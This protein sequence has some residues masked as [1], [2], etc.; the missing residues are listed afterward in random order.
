MK[1][2]TLILGMMGALAA[3]LLVGAPSAVADPATETDYAVD[4]SIPDGLPNV[5]DCYDG[6]VEGYVAVR[7]CLEK[8]GDELWVRD[9]AADGHSVELF[10]KNYL[11]DASGNWGLYRQGR[12]VDRLGSAADWTYCE[13]DFYEN[14]TNPNAHG[15]KGSGL[16]LHPC[17]VDR[18]CAQEYRWVVNNK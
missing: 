15:G 1:R 4:G 8:H 13:K 7:V 2:I 9:M 14:Q 5:D 18:G 11:K 6:V 17:V 10:W 12:C 3:I 16:R